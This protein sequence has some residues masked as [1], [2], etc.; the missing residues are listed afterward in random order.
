MNNNNYS[1][2]PIY[3]T[4]GEQNHRKPYAFGDIYPLY[5]PIGRILPFQIELPRTGSGIGINCSLI[6]VN[7]NIEEE[8]YYPNF[9]QDISNSGMD[10]LSSDSNYWRI[11][12]ASTR[13]LTGKIFEPGQYFIEILIS[14]D[15]TY[16]LYSEI[17]T[18]V[19]PTTNFLTIQW[20]S[21][22]NLHTDAGIVFYKTTKYTVNHILYLATE[23][24]KPDYEFEDEGES[25]DGL[26]FATKQ[27]SKKI[28]K[29]TFVAP[30]YMCDVLRLIP[31]ADVVQVHDPYGR[32]YD[33]QSFLPTIKWLTQG[34]LAS[35]EC[36]FVA[37]SIVKKISNVVS[38]LGDFNNDYND[39]YNNL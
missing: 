2:L 14:E 4:K 31:L 8:V 32:Q 35:V 22:N 7:G 15:K 16:S 11:V 6:K 23:L 9:F 38:G 24:G 1:V 12:Y 13:L 27:L 25:R 30:E 17:F 10:L 39:D 21:I 28:Y 3:K 34:N 5:S 19:A 33:C 29:F 37:D 36:E 18:W 26:F 20:Y